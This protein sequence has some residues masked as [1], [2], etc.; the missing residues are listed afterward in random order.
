MPAIT[1]SRV[2]T[3]DQKIQSNSLP[4]KNRLYFCLKIKK[5][6]RGGGY[7]IRTHEGLLPTRFP[8]VRHRPLG[9]SSTDLCF[10]L[11]L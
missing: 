2:S 10:Q 9:E 6:N 4:L 11:R 5:I 8:S 3:E 7:E 1:I